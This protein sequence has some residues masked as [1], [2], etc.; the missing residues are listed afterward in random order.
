MSEF[1]QQQCLCL[2]WMDIKAHALFCS[3]LSDVMSRSDYP[4]GYN[5]SHGPLYAPQG[6]GYPPPPAYDSSYPS[7]GGWPGTQPGPQ[8]GQPSAPYPTGP[9]APLYSGQPGGYPPGPYPGQPYPAG[10]PGAGYPQPPPMPPVIP[11]TMPSD[12]FSSGTTISLCPLIQ[13]EYF[14]QRCLRCLSFNFISKCH[15][16]FLLCSTDNEGDQFAASGDGW[17]DLSIRHAFIRKVK[18]TN[19]T[20]VTL[21]SISCVIMTFKSKKQVQ[22]PDRVCLMHVWSISCSL[23]CI[24]RR[25][26]ACTQS[27]VH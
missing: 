3:L 21:F 17:D 22:A 4:P 26:F 8:P 19:R 16:P 6:G 9:N 12:V 25:R 7:Y 15:Q 5:D 14:H 2:R 18:Y 27:L 1:V 11:P 13:W 20:E 24:N 10:P 23:W